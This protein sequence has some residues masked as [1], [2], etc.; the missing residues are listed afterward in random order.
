MLSFILSPIGKLA[1]AAIVLLLIA[2]L[3]YRTGQQSTQIDNLKDTVKAHETRNEIN[4]AVRNLDD[5][6]RCLALGGLSV[7]CDK[8]RGLDEASEGE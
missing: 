6:R 8:L 1:G 7:E 3:V 4:E 2:G 5:F